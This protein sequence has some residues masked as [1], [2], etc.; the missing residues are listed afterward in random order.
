[1]G[2]MQRRLW[3]GDFFQSHWL[4]Q[5]SKE[6][7]GHLS[8]PLRSYGKCVSSSSPGTQRHCIMV[9]AVLFSMRSAKVVFS[10]PLVVPSLVQ[11][12]QEGSSSIS[13]QPSLAPKMLLT[14]LGGLGAFPCQ[15]CSPSSFIQDCWFMASRGTFPWEAG[16]NSVAL[17]CPPLATSQGQGLL[18]SY[19]QCK[20]F[21]SKHL[22]GDQVGIHTTKAAHQGCYHIRESTTLDAPSQVI[23]QR[24]STSLSSTKPTLSAMCQA[25]GKPG[26][27]VTKKRKRSLRKFPLLQ[28]QLQLN[29]SQ[30]PNSN[31]GGW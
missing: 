5:A 11:G 27:T 30:G 9:L 21:Y 13:L 24:S 14:L 6:L 1:M 15:L 28:A 3:E 20:G 29:H 12:F 18:F 31:A 17:C 7:K 2:G 16:S 19:R 23:L 22:P 26:K 8:F 10:F 25:P 4:L